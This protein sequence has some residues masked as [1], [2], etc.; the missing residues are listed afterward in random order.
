MERLLP[1]FLSEAF[2]DL[3]LDA[4]KIR[5]KAMDSLRTE[6]RESIDF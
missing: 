6:F 3:V 5:P 1:F 2:Q 4:K